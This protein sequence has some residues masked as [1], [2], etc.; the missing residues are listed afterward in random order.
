MKKSKLTAKEV[1]D[2]FDAGE[3]LTDFFT[4]EVD[5]VTYKKKRKLK[6]P[7]NVENIQYLGDGVLRITFDGTVRDIDISALDLNKRYPKLKDPIYLQKAFFDEGCIK[8]PDGGPW[9]DADELGC[10]PETT[11]FK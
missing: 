4:E 3:E 10:I 7:T 11:K 9:I 8:W 2:K 1:E 6:G 5:P